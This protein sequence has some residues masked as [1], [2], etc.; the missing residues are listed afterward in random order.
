MIDKTPP[1]PPNTEERPGP[2]WDFAAFSRLELE[3]R[4]NSDKDFDPGVFHDA[5]ALVLGKINSLN[6]SD[7]GGSDDDHQ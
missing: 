6:D 4:R 5:V 3:R 2:A 7:D 1:K